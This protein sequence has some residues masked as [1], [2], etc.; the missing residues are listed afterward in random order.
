MQF[1]SHIQHLEG[2]SESGISAW[3]GKGENAS[4]FVGDWLAHP[5][6][7]GTQASF[8]IKVSKME[9]SLQG[10]ILAPTMQLGE[11]KSLKTI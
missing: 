3:G 7:D 10:R 2:V 6:S 8:P 11:L 1:L 5:L 4:D 9:V